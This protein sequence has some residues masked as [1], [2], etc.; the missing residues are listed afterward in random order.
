M[1][2]KFG[3]YRETA[4]DAVAGDANLEKKRGRGRD[5]RMHINIH[6]RNGPAPRVSRMGRRIKAMPLESRGYAGLIPSSFAL[7][8]VVEGSQGEPRAGS[9]VDSQSNL[10]KG[11]FP[12]KVGARIH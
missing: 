8:S 7:H 10:P 5:A 9:T 2:E 4:P 6:A 3:A 12:A 11:V 1:P